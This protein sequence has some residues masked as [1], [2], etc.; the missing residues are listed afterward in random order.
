LHADVQAEA[1]LKEIDLGKWEGLSKDEVRHMYPG[2]YEER[3]QDMAGYRTPKGE[4]FQDVLDRVLPFAKKYLESTSP[5]MVVTHAGVIRVLS[6]WAE[7]KP[8]QRLFD[9]SPAPGSLT[10]IE[11]KRKRVKLIQSG[12]QL[13]MGQTNTAILPPI[14]LKKPH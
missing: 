6:C 10:V 13:T 3:G 4:S 12:I 8:I 11:Q 7:Q 2:A 5:T 9:F 1:V 14:G